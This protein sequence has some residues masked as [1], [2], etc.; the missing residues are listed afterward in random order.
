MSTKLLIALAVQR[1]IYNVLVHRAGVERYSAPL[2][3]L[4]IDY[5]ITNRLDEG[6]IELE[7]NDIT[8]STDS[9]QEQ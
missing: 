2:V 3:L 4:M 7:S 5:G 1:T 8:C 9:G 6:S